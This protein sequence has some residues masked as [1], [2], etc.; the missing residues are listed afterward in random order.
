LRLL[1][2]YRLW[3]RK[4]SQGHTCGHFFARLAALQP[5]ER[6]LK[7]AVALLRGSGLEASDSFLKCSAFKADR[8]E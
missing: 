1:L 6:S 7:T 2:L 4:R 8:N 3:V 5:V